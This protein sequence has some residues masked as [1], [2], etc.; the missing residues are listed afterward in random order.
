[1]EIVERGYRLAL[2]HF[3]QVANSA[4]EV[5]HRA[6]QIAVANNAFLGLEV[7]QDEPPAIER[8]DL[9]DH[10]RRSGTASIAGLGAGCREAFGNVD[11]DAG[12]PQLPRLL[13]EIKAAEDKARH[14]TEGRAKRK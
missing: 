7:D 12:K 11:R 9:G 13:A 6:L 8:V 14:K 3:C 2:A 1:M 4:H 5:A 10:R